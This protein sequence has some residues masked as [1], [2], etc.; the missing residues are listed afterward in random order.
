MALEAIT[1]NPRKEFLIP[2]GNAPESDLLIA[3]KLV[4][5]IDALK[6]DIPMFL[7]L[8]MTPKDTPTHPHLYF[9]CSES[10]KSILEFTYEFRNTALKKGHS[11]F[12]IEAGLDELF[13]NEF[14][15]SPKAY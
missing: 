2:C 1:K 3:D 8:K 10:Q 9:I 11:E 15:N 13:A 4:R 12:E 7:M 6:L 14:S 5:R